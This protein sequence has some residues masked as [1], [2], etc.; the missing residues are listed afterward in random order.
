[1]QNTSMTSVIFTIFDCLFLSERPSFDWNTV[2]QNALKTETQNQIH[3][4][5]KFLNKFL[6]SKLPEIFKHEFYEES[7]MYLYNEWFVQKLKKKS[8][9]IS[10]IGI[11]KSI[12][13]YISFRPQYLVLK[14]RMIRENTERAKFVL[15]KQRLVKE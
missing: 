14:R 4:A 7:I 15:E 5:I 8:H 6:G 9:S 2:K 3:I 10:I 13:E 1:M 12:V 11:I